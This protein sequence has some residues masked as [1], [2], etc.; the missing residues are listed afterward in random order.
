MELCDYCEAYSVDETGF[1]ESCAENE[2]EARDCAVIESCGNLGAKTRAIFCG[3]DLGEYSEEE[4]ALLAIVEAMNKEK[5][6]PGVYKISDHGNIL[7]VESLPDPTDYDPRCNECG[8]CHPVVEHDDDCE[9]WHEDADAECVCGDNV[10]GRNGYVS[11]D[12]AC[13]NAAS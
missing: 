11:V 8:K 1:C 13:I 3:R 9:Y 5:W 2:I 6:F 7:P 10:I 12:V 4:D